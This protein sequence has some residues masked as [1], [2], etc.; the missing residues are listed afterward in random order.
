MNFIRA[1][2]PSQRQELLSLHPSDI[3]VTTSTTSCCSSIHQRILLT[4]LCTD[5]QPD[6][7]TRNP[8]EELTDSGNSTLVFPST[9]S[10]S[11]ARSR[12]RQRL[13]HRVAPTA[14]STASSGVHSI[15]HSLS[16]S[17]PKRRGATWLGWLRA[18]AKGETRSNL[19]VGFGV[20]E[21][22]GAHK[23]IHT[24]G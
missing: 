14:S 7:G 4:T 11:R 13:Q 22:S 15:A 16:N 12:R 17:S 24:V 18:A 8:R 10:S 5:T 1:R 9:T 19:P 21:G 3:A 23:C 6:E 2:L 20:K